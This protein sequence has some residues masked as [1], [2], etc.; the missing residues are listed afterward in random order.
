MNKDLD[1][2]LVPNG[3]YTDALNIRIANSEGGDVG[4]IENSLGN[5]QLTNLGLGD[6]VK[7]IGGIADGSLEKLYWL[8]KSNSGCFVVEYDYRN[9]VESFVLKDTRS[10]E[11][12]VL[13]FDENHLVTGINIIIDSDNGE[14]FLAWCDGDNKPPRF[15]NVERAKGYGENGF[16]NDDISLIKK[17]PRYA[18]E[19]DFRHT[20][21]QLE[22]NIEDKF[23]AFAYRYKY[24]DGQ[25]SALSSFTNYAFSPKQFRLDYQTM[26]NEGMVN[27]FNALNISFDTGPKTVTDIQLCFKESNSNTV[28]EIDTFNKEDLKWGDNEPRDFEFVN[29]KVYRALPQDELFRT[30]DAVPLYA[31]GQEMIGNRLVFGNY[32]EG[33]DMVDKDGNKVNMDYRLELAERDI[34]LTDISVS[35]GSDFRAYIDFSGISLMKGMKVL[36]EVKLFIAGDKYS[37]QF[38]FDLPRAFSNA[39]EMSQSDE[40]IYFVETVMTGV[41]KEGYKVDDPPPGSTV[42]EITN[43]DVL[44]FNNNVI[45]IKAPTIVFELDGGGEDTWRW[46]WEDGT[47]VLYRESSSVESLKSNRSYEV[48]II[49]LDKYNRASTVMTSKNNTIYVPSENAIMQTHIGVFLRHKAP[50]W[51]DRYKFVIK[52]NNL[53]YHTIYTNVFY[54][55]GLYR[56]VKLEGESINKV[57]EGDTL[58]VKSDLGGP[59]LNLVKTKVIEIASKDKNFLEGNK[60]EQ[61]DEIKE[62]EG[63]YMKIKP[64]GFDMNNN[65]STALTFE[66]GNHLRYPNRA[67]TE[68]MFGGNNDNGVF[69]LY[70]VNPG[71]R[72]YIRIAF[73]AKGSISYFAEY[74]RE[75]ISAG[76]Y[77]DVQAWFDAEVGDLGQFGRDYTWNG[78]DDIWKGDQTNAPKG[79]GQGDSNNKN[80]GWG[81]CD[82][83]GDYVDKG[84]KRFYVTAHRAGTASRGITSSVKFEIYFSRGTVIFETEPRDEL[85]NDI[86]YE[87]AQTFDIVDGYHQGNSISQTPTNPLM[88]SGLDFFNCYLQG[89]GAE[90]YRYKDQFNSKNLNMDLR[91]TL[92]S[93]D[94]YRRN[95]RKASL[96]YGGVYEQ[97]TNYNGINEFN[98][99]LVNWKDLDDAHGSVQKLFSRDNNLIVLQEDKVHNILFSKDVLYDADGDGTLR[100]SSQVLGSAVPYAG[101]YGISLNPESF[102]YFGN[103]IYFTD[104]K[105]GV[106]IRLSRDGITPVSMYGM[107]GWFR[108]YFRRNGSRKRFGAYDPYIGEYVLALNEEAES[109]SPGT[110]AFD[111]DVKG[112][113]SFF[114]FPPD[115]ML[116]MNN[117][118]FS[119]RDGQL[120]L[121]NS[122]NVPRNNF[123]GVQYG[124]S[125]TVSLNDRPGIEKSYL[126]IILKGNKTWDIKFNSNLTEGELFRNEFE[127]RKSRYFAYTRRDEN[128]EDFSSFSTNGVGLLTAYAG[129]TLI[130][131]STV[132]AM[133]CAGDNLFQ[134]QGSNNVLIGEIDMISDDEIIVS[135]LVNSPIPNGFCYATKNARVE[136]GELRG[137]YMKAKL[138]N[139]DTDYTE[140]F[141]IETNTAETHV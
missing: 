20:Q 15:V 65:D 36:F 113:P 105:R 34:A 137:Y 83:N 60:N 100:E 42:K 97:S 106:L 69:E 41:F 81:F 92:V 18:P 126:S 78:I 88:V 2:R 66:G 33:Y 70:P 87:S 21:S 75:F 95:V 5:E 1:E 104:E 58:I 99:S 129:S 54:E 28:Y 51:A 23:L 49:Y 138:E 62:L 131:E 46:D 120:W 108:D 73:R 38:E 67:Y 56:W 45:T 125:V 123:Y 11:E 140:L 127:R 80:S 112:F 96:T 76:S 32:A 61:G 91:P 135:N 94:E 53:D 84:G 101:E 79:Y 116:G 52:Q 55:D 107:R 128:T 40:F 98:T 136:G 50:Y 17:P 44:A 132:N 6:N 13:G 12:N 48:G 8:L 102:A 124:S 39:K 115:L 90:S 72:I 133:V 7:T 29:N 25:Y 27:A 139:D 118:F 130:F 122:E 10:G 109:N 82:E 63:L 57:K 24:L 119:I 64:T 77:P 93:K 117:R 9:N 47:H 111:E 3:Q 22:N 89:N 86:Y 68:P 14:V 134:V 114:S 19:L 37:E 16:N 71:T 4:A 59:V 35:I 121:H 26:E 43:F 31:K 110:L 141:E 103:R 30:Y 85:N 74:E